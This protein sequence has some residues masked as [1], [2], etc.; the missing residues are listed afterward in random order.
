MKWLQRLFRRE[1]V[2]LGQQGERVA[3]QWLKRR[4][5]RIL[6]RNMSVGDDEADLIAL[7]PDGRTIVIVEVKTR[8]SETPLPEFSINRTKQ[9]RMARLAARLQQRA[10]Y[11][12]CPFRFD[13]IAIVWPQGATPDIRHHPGAFDSPW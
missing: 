3:A 8:R 12:N 6:Q 2:P 13:A 9:Y 7:D 5:Y 11:A 1:A 4:G 10:E